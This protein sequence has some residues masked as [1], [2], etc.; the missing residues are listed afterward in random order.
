MISVIGLNYGQ[1]ILDLSDAQ[2]VNLYNRLGLRTHIEILKQ[3]NRP[4]GKRQP[5]SLDHC[6]IKEFPAFIWLITEGRKKRRGGEKKRKYIYNIHISTIVEGHF[7]LTSITA[8]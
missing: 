3:P 5:K 1:S 8:G 4:G 7:I 6:P 2:L